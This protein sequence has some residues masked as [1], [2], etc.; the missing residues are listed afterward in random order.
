MTAHRTTDPSV[1]GTSTVSVVTFFGTARIS[2]RRRSPESTDGSPQ[3]V[4]LRDLLRLRSGRPWS[5]CHRVELTLDVSGSAGFEVSATLRI[6]VPASLSFFVVPPPLDVHAT[7]SSSSKLPL[8]VEYVTPHLERLD[9]RLLP[10]VNVTSS[11]REEFAGGCDVAKRRERRLQGSGTAKNDAG[12]VRALIGVY[13]FEDTTYLT[14]RRLNSRTR[15]APRRIAED[16]RGLAARAEDV[17]G[18]GAVSVQRDRP[19]LRADSFCTSTR[20]PSGSPGCPLRA[21]PSIA[22]VGAEARPR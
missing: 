10:T 16:E 19:A 13:P 1:V 6:N 18:R 11:G 15:W 17:A 12:S 4:V 21:L 5:A 7:F 9:R 3:P 8:A 2:R 20:C 22:G 14:C